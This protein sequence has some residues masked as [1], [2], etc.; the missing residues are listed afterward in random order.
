MSWYVDTSAFVKLI[1]EEPESAAMRAWWDDHHPRVFSSDLL[2]TETVRATRRVSTEAEVA[3][4]QALETIDLLS[5]GVDTYGQAGTIEPRELRTLDALH[6]VAAV[7]AGDDLEGVVTYDD[8]LAGACR[9]RSI[10]I[11]APARRR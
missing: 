9:A 5:F 11:A 2:R 1:V 3:A 4:H 7:A 10:A 8:R 6:L